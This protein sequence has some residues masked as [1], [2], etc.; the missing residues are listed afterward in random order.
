MLPWKSKRALY[1]STVSHQHC[2]RVCPY[3]QKRR[4][5]TSPADTLEENKEFYA[6][7]MLVHFLSQ[8]SNCDFYFNQYYHV[9]PNMFYLQILPF[10]LYGMRSWIHP[11]QMI[12]ASLFSNQDLQTCI[13]V[14]S[15]PYIPFLASYQHRSCTTS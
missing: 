3:F 12:L 7:K 8:T 5:F 9:N 2:A 6:T 14:D 4:A 13:A 15:K 10:T 1:R 11:K